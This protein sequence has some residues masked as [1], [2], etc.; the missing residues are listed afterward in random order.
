[1][2]N[3]QIVLF[4]AL[5]P[6][7]GCFAGGLL[8]EGVRTPRWVVGA[9]LHGAAGIAIALISIEIMP[10]VTDT[11]PIWLIATAFFAGAVASY[12][13]ARSIDVIRRSGGGENFR[14]WMIY[15]A[16][17]ADLFTDG[18]MT[19]A[20]SA[21]ALQLGFLIAF[22]QFIA[23]TPG[24]FAAAA[25]LRNNDVKRSRRLTAAVLLAVPAILS[26]VIGYFILK[27]APATVQ[28]SVLCFVA[29]ILLLATIEDMIPEGDAPRPP[30][31]SSSLA[32]AIGFCALALLTQIGKS[33]N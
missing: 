7:A 11:I 12:F 15:A 24:G 33:S 1:M 18:L 25:N 5:L 30:R 6:A 23:N 8:A 4:Y 14:A 27:D 3:F 19:G 20:G 9:L 32:F 13:L 21:A 10:R 2:S 22:A 16:I 28:D 29:G 31:W 17:G 26:A